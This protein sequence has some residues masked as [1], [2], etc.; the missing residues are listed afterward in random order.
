META[1][2][3]LLIAHLLGDFFLQSNSWVIDKERKKLRSLKLYGHTLLHI[4][5][6][7]LLFFSWEVWSLALI[8]GISHL[9][10]DALKLIYQRAKTKRF[11]FFIDQALHI[12]V[13]VA[14]WIHYYQPGI[15]FAFLQQPQFWVLVGSILLL[16][17]P[18]AIFIKIIIAKWVPITN[19]SSASSLQDAGKFIGMLERLLIFLFV[20]TRHFE[21]VGFLL[22]A[23]S[24]LSLFS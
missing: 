24:I 8:I 12:L 15:D 18:T 21:A 9:I 2:I 20:C 13:I 23:K 10:I 16:T 5:L 1:L 17:S 3:K 7:F 22:A 19:R 11:W 4:G 14:C 6:I